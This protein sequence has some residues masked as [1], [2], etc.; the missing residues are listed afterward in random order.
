MHQVLEMTPKGRSNWKGKFIKSE[1]N[2]LHCCQDNRQLASW[3]SA[4]SVAAI[5]PV[6]THL[7][8]L[9]ILPASTSNIITSS[10]HHNHQLTLD[11]TSWP[12][13]PQPPPK[14]NATTPPPTP[15]PLP[16]PAAGPVRHRYGALRQVRLQRDLQSER[17]ARAQMMPAR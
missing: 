17:L 6:S 10:Q 16:V 1:L 12:P 14:K 11:P 2:E 5:L 13:T 9:L 7:R 3:E 15:P 8:D 4:N